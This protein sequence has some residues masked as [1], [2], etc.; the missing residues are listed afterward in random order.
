MA[1]CA[2]HKQNLTGDEKQN[3]FSGQWINVERHDKGC[4]SV[5]ES[6]CTATEETHQCYDELRNQ[7]FDV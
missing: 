3:Y 4:F 7:S 5:G 6:E 2:E 1:D